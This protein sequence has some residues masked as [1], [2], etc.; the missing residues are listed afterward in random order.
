[1]LVKEGDKRD[2]GAGYFEESSAMDHS[3]A[4]SRLKRS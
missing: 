2:Y 1:M 4:E 3:I